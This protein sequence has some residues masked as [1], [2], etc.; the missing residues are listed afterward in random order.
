ML[1][2]LRKAVGPSGALA[3]VLLDLKLD[4]NPGTNL[5][6]I[7]RR[8]GEAEPLGTLRGLDEGDWAVMTEQVKSLLD[9]A[10]RSRALFSPIYARLMRSKCPHRRA[11]PADLGRLLRDLITLAS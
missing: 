10:G 7:V 8:L 4:N 2:T 1:S 9:C 6:G 3:T 5:K 11:A